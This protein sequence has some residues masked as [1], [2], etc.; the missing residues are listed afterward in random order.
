MTS[1]SE[2]IPLPAAP[3]RRRA[4]DFVMLTKPRLVSLVLVTTTVGF[5]VGA[6]EGVDPFL[7]LYTILG[8][9]LAG[10]GA[11]A[12]NQYLER[13]IDARMER[14]RLRPL[15]DGRLAPTEALAFGVLTASTGLVLLSLL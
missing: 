2:S 9:A 11:M 10:A 1:R 4:A 12:L 8:T 15:P 7:L 3:A 14:T 13:D 6:R 5:W